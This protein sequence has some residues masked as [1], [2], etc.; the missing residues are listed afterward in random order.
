[1]HDLR[2]EPKDRPDVLCRA[3]ELQRGVEKPCTRNVGSTLRGVG[4]HFCRYFVPNFSPDNHR[5]RRH[6]TD[7]YFPSPL[8]EMPSSIW[9]CTRGTIP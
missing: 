6:H 3:L 7:R 5:D 8:Y 9:M 1:M 4:P 2:A